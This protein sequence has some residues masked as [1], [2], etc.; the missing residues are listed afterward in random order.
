MR[1]LPYSPL[2]SAGAGKAR[3]ARDM[4]AEEYRF[5]RGRRAVWRKCG[6]ASVL[7]P[8]LIFACFP[9]DFAGKLA[10]EGGLWYTK[11]NR[12]EQSAEKGPLKKE[13][14]FPISSRRQS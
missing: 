11:D 8:Y 10:G 14:G 5:R 12:I 7:V 6:L 4:P 3:C 1:R 13:R 9:L 2:I